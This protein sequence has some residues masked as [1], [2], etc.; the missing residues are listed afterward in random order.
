MKVLG[1][2]LARAGS[3]GLPNKHLLP[4]LGRPVISYTLDHAAG[5][6]GHARSVVHEFSTG[7]VLASRLDPAIPVRNRAV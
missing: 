3:V 2:V 4:L 5:A 6:R 7:T 1:V